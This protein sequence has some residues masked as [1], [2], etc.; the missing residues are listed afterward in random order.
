MERAEKGTGA[1]ND[2]G[3]AA[4]PKQAIKTESRRPA[5][6]PGVDKR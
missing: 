2:P 1:V 4:D 5:P 3:G 6:A